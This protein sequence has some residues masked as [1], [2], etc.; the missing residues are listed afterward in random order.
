MPVQFENYTRL[1]SD[2]NGSGISSGEHLF[3][4]EPPNGYS[5]FQCQRIRCAVPYRALRFS[6]AGATRHQF[7]DDEVLARDTGYVQGAAND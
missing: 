2:L 1:L 3:K 7:P 6:A 5:Q 4:G